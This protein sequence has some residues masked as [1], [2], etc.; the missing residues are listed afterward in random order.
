MMRNLPMPRRM[1]IFP[2]LVGLLLGAASLTPSLIPRDWP[3]QGI[4]AG[5]SVAL[6]Y[7][8]TQFFLTLWRSLEIPVL[9]GRP[10]LIAHVLLAIPV[11]AVLAFSVM[12]TGDWQN[13]IR[14]RM[15]LPELEAFDTTKMLLIAAVT[16]LALYLVGFLIQSLFNLLRKRL[17][18]YIPVTSANVL[19]LLLAAIVVLIVTRDGV[20]N[21]LLKG[22]DSSYAAAQHLSDPSTPAPAKEWQSGSAQSLVDWSLMGKPGRN[23]VAF[24]PT[25]ADIE[26]FNN[27]PA[28]DPLRIYVGLAQDNS[29]EDRA[30]IAFNE[31]LRVGAFDRKVLVVAS[32]TG[33]GWMDAAS[34][35]VLEYMHD[36]D[37]ATVAAQ[38]SYLQSP[39]ALIF[40]T[41]AGLDQ[42][43]ALMN[44]VYQH[45]LTLPRETRPKLYMHG[46]S[47]G[48]WSSMYAFNP[49]QMMNEPIDGALWVGP[50][51]PSTL[52]NQANSA[53]TPGSPIILPEVDDGVVI[54]Y[55]SQFAKP[56]RSGKPWGRVHILF[57][58]Y[59]SDPI[60][61]YSP[62]ALWREPLWMREKLAP[63]V[64]PK[65]S[66]TPIVTQLQLTVDLL[67]STAPPPGFGH[68]YHAR[69]YIDAWAAVTEPDNWSDEAAERLKGHCGL[70]EEVLGCANGG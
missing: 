31:M 12:L 20:V 27:R 57:L 22:A 56:L 59:G 37:V 9:R 16:F 10:A 64:S 14:V 13:S 55:A 28:K 63:D 19:G 45:W 61:F 40:E 17:A 24:G 21:R 53:R 41:N 38:Y 60:V 68:T 5:V 2:L 65:L 54:R 33:T 26:A 15:N 18:R 23:F 39:L 47:L 49:F 50:P 48:A 3:L 29:A 44:R 52:W 58:Q 36:G 35:D 6:G 51:F 67:L 70:S 30:D 32:P 46:I 25:R 7:M 43:T 66:F 42:A 62:S 1:A 4:L 69:D 11:L 34:Y 8:V